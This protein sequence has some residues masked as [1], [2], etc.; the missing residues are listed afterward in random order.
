MQNPSSQTSQFLKLLDYM[1]EFR[2]KSVD[3]F[4]DVSTETV[5]N[6][7]SAASDIFQQ[8]PTVL[9]LDTPIHIIGDIHGQFYD[10]L[11]FFEITG[12]PPNSKYL[13]LGDYV[14]RGKH[15]IEVM[16]MLLSL[17]VIY[18]SDIYLL[19]GNHEQHSI[20]QTYGFRADC[21]RFG[22]SAED[23]FNAFNQLFQ[24]LPIM[25]V[26]SKKIC[27]V[28][29]GIS[30]HL[31][32]MQDIEKIK[33]PVYISDSGLLCDLLWADPSNEI[34]WTDGERGLGKAFGHDVLST[35]LERN[36][37]DVLIRAHQAVKEGYEFSFNNKL[38]TIFSCPNY[39]G[40]Y[41][42]AGAMV[43]VDE[44]LN[45]TIRVLKTFATIE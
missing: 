1:L 44:K 25:S 21:D 26:V 42:N 4:A 14:D 29:G 31:T 17:K 38:L 19:R 2:M 37:F 7:C 9:E 32:T 41:D 18:P 34:G 30:K 6:L 36:N 45:C 8:E 27:C 35:F 12:Y 39:V 33:R 11:R 3:D 43:S 10:M 28:H 20:N 5:L 13:F 23:V 40:V 15:S 16:L 24:L 22:D